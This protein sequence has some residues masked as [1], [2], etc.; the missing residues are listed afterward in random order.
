MSSVWKTCQ[1]FQNLK[2]HQMN[3]KINKFNF[4][5]MEFAFLSLK[6]DYTDQFFLIWRNLRFGNI[7]QV[8]HTGL[9]RLQRLSSHFV[10]KYSKWKFRNSF[11]Q[12]RHVQRPLGILHFNFQFESYWKYGTNFLKSFVRSNRF[13]S[14][15]LIFSNFITSELFIWRNLFRGAG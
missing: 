4:L 13:R 9:V 3:K 7:C 15:N 11:F 5:S 2:F 1:I 10:T 12:A 6:P 8:F 14:H